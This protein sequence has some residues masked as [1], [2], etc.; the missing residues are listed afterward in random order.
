MIRIKKSAA[1]RGGEAA[2]SQMKSF[3]IYTLGCK[4]NQYDSGSL[5]EKLAS[6]GF[7]MGEKNTDLAI[8]N[9]CSVTGS[10]IAKNRETI[11]RA[12]KENPGA[13]IILTGCWAKVYEK[14]A[15]L[16]GV[17]YVCPLDEVG[18]LARE[19]F[20]HEPDDFS[21][22]SSELSLRKR[23]KDR[24]R[25]FIKVQDG[26]EQYCSYCIIPY[27]RGKLK[28][29]PAEEVIK[30]IKTAVSE[31]YRE[32]I[33]SGIHLGLYGQEVK[34]LPVG[35]AGEKLGVKKDLV[36]LLREI[37][38]I[39]NLGRVRL[40]SI[41]VTEVN[42]ELVILIVG[43][44][45][46]CKHL[47][48]PLQAGCDKILKRMN[49]PYDTNY[50]REKVLKIRKLIP[51]MAITTDVIVG[52]PGE[53]ENDFEETV[54]F[55]KEMNFSKVHVFSFSAHERTPAAKMDGV[56]DKKEIK[57]RSSVLRKLSDELEKEYKNN[58]LGKELEVV[59]D[60][61]S[62]EGN[63]RGKTEY[64]FD[65]DFGK[66]NIINGEPRVGGIVTVNI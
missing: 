62:K 12:K 17:D 47:H 53:T 2:F 57:R 58:F 43:N 14:E 3:K 64:Y 36:C 41:E 49:R 59:V 19:I 52:F 25:Y 31:G 54:R 23:N 48:V 27:T 8:V 4:V 30:E 33:L 37:L 1:F 38:E 16:S 34:S 51:D 29:R 24:S 18:E 56:V 13:K 39:E 26:C 7:G 40:S 11:E 63:Y 60:G 65:I 22:P 20:S 9:T 45:R 44:K 6:L 66:G 5:G 32:I 50:F 46:I 21:C 10:A 55:I 15:Q 35:Q 28:S 61:R 42:D